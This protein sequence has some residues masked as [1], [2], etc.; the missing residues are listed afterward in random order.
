VPSSKA[1]VL[2]ALIAAF[3]A[4][5]AGCGSSSDDDTGSTSATAT[6]C[7]PGALATHSDG[8]LTVATDKP[9]YP[10]YFIDD[11]PANGM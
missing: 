2:L 7:S 3:A 10:P 1:P 9:A 8:V 6:N 5:A 4:L 11:D